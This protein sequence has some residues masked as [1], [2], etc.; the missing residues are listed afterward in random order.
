MFCVFIL[1]TDLLFFNVTDKIKICL[2][3][4]DNNLVF[5]S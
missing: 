3:I 5:I 2:L 1:F 4:F